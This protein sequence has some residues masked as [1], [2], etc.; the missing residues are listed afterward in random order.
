MSTLSK[1]DI[2]IK[3]A[4]SYNPNYLQT[5][6]YFGIFPFSYHYYQKLSILEKI[7]YKAQFH[8]LPF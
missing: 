6:V 5:S 4:F 2:I 8:D 3:K 7:I 1:R